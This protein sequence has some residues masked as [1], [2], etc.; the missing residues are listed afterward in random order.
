MAEIKPCVSMTV[1]RIPASIEGVFGDCRF[2][3]TG[4][5]R[6][7][8]QWM[9]L[10]TPLGDVR[11]CPSCAQESAD[12]GLL[13]FA[14]GFSTTVDGEAGVVLLSHKVIEDYARC[15]TYEKLWR[16]MLRCGQRSGTRILT[17]TPLLTAL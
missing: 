14:S 9:G 1:F 3:Q 11:C 12:A 17:T 2:S 13:A 15:A 4:V 7:Q 10:Q 16:E 5:E 6:M 8:S